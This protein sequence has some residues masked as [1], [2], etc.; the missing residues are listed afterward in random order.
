[1]RL[2]RVRLTVFRIMLAVAACAVV[3]DFTSEG[4][5]GPTRKRYEQ[6]VI[7]ADNHARMGSEYRTNAGGDPLMLR[8]AAWHEHMRQVFE[9][10]ADR[11]ESPLPM[12]QPFPPEGWL[13]PQD[14]AHTASQ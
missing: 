4:L 12:S 5:K 3:S 11:S 8:I 6:C 13:G 1:M 2:P 9:D 14:M 7:I 10:A